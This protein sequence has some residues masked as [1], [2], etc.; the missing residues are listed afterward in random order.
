MRLDSIVSRHLE[1][2]SRLGGVLTLASK[3]PSPGRP[4]DF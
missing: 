2:S 3:L 1:E 4:V